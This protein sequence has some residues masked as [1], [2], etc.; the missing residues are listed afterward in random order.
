[1]ARMSTITVRQLIDLLEGED[2]DAKVLFT[3]DY[4]DYSHTDQAL[5]I[6]GETEEVLIEKSAYSHSGFAIAKD[7]DDPDNT[8][9]YLV[10]R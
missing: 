9:K 3:C 1:M 2:Q 8:K 10:I 5:A 7:D 6:S 4:G